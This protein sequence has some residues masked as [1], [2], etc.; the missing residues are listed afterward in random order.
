MFQETNWLHK[1]KTQIYKNLVIL[2]NAEP[3]KNNTYSPLPFLSDYSLDQMLQQTGSPLSYL[4]W[5][6]AFFSTLH[7]IKQLKKKHF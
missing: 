5:V 7:S 6:V 2:Y 1:T 4:W 3:N